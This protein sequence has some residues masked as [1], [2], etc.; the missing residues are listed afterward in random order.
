LIGGGILIWLGSLVYFQTVG[1]IS[2]ADFGGFF[3]MGIGVLIVIGGLLA[4][5]STGRP[6]FGYLIGGLVLIVL[7]AFA[8]EGFSSYVGAG[9]L[10]FLGLLVIIFAYSARRGSPAP[11]PST[12]T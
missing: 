6:L 5:T 12:P 3:L 8:I 10:V 1:A 2:G 7:G 11:S 4:R 9:F